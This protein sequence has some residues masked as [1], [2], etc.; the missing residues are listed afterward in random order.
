MRLIKNINKEWKFIKNNINLEQILK[1]KSKKVD[2]PHTWNNLDGQDGGSNYYR[3]TC[4]YYK[5][6]GKISRENDEVVYL[7]FE[8]R[9]AQ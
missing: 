7:E 1:S 9:I 8:G 6:L 5:K 2:L 4:W 3:G